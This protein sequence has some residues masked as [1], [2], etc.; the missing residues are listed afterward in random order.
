MMQR[1]FLFSAEA[2]TSAIRARESTNPSSF[3]SQES[4]C[5]RRLVL[6]P[7]VSESGPM[8]PYGR[9]RTSGMSVTYAEPGLTHSH[10]LSDSLN[11]NHDPCFQRY[12]NQSCLYASTLDKPLLVI[13]GRSTTGAFIWGSSIHTLRQSLF[14][15]LDLCVVPCAGKN[16]WTA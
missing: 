15:Y 16:C 13:S 10:P 6:D 3:I 8:T 4:S 12:Q 14:A 9:W 2:K 7:K 5:P 11:H 1:A